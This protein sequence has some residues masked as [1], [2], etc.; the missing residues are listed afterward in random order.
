[1]SALKNKRNIRQSA[2]IAGGFCGERFCSRSWLAQKGKLAQKRKD[3]K[4]QKVMRV[5]LLCPQGALKK[6][7]IKRAGSALKNKRNI[8]QSAN[9]AGGFC[10]ERFGS[11]CGSR[12]KQTGAVF[13][14]CPRLFFEQDSAVCQTSP[15]GST[16]RTA[17]KIPL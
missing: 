14:Y 17:K 2:N 12:R 13:T 7:L 6:I 4:R 16:L 8:R 9:I 1:M 3:K 10:G 15:A 11:R 5:L